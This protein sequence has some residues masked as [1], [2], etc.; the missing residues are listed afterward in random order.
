MFSSIVLAFS[1]ASAAVLPLARDVQAP[2]GY[3][4]GLENY[5]TYSARY[6]A[7]SCQ[8][9]HNTTFFAKC[10]HPM[11]KT[12]TLADRPAE[13][14]PANTEEECDDDESSSAAPAAT[15]APATPA[16]AGALAPAPAQQKSSS[17][18]THSSSA[19][20]A[21]S[22]PPVVNAAP[23]PAA[24]APKPSPPAPKPAAPS[25]A[26]AP[27]P[28]AASPSNE[29]TGGFGTWFTQNGVA[30][31]CGT[32]HSDSDL[33]VALDEQA[34]GPGCGNSVHCGKTITITDLAT[35]NTAQ[36]T[37]ADCCPTC[38][39]FGSVD[40]STGLF[41]KFAPLSVGELNIKYVFD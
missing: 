9:Q 36:G 13:C 8:T 29:I 1:V 19:T 35:G 24:P 2:P 5:G 41:Q 3:W 12:E 20:P 22:P 37:V 25:P 15:P 27:A 16:P 34:Y 33:I 39:N 23:K 28:A 6:T 40:M 11:L 4:S 30:G 17:S 21:P 31:A 38:T 7:L 18:S 26:P 10:C 32:V 14:N